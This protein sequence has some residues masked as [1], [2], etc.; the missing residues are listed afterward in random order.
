MVFFFLGKSEE[1]SEWR[2]VIRNR[3]D[4]LK[5]FC[6]IIWMNNKDA[7]YTRLKIYFIDFFIAFIVFIIII[8]TLIQTCN[9]PL[10]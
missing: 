4:V 6:I 3:K 5:S 10:R 8:I 7:V 2:K 1:T 9:K